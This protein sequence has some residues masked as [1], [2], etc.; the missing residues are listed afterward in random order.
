ME[1][2]DGRRKPRRPISDAEVILDSAKAL[3]SDP[4]IPICEGKYPEGNMG[5]VEFGNDNR[6]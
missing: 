6:K 1:D 3:K 2:Y 4:G 5:P